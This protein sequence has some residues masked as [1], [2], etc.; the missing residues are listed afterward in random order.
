VAF[1][2]LTY[3]LDGGN[4]YVEVVFW[5]D[6]ETADAEAEA[7]IRTLNRDDGNAPVDGEGAVLVEAQEEI[8]T[9]R[10]TSAEETGSAEEAPV[11]EAQEDG[12]D[13]IEVG[14]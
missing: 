8:A 13:A 11:A 3:I 1:N 14:E 12:S 10:R 2:T 4:E 6:G 7:I 5:L 9:A